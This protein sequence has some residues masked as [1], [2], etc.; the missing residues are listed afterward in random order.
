MGTVIKVRYHADID[1]LEY[2]GGAKSNWIDLRCAEDVY[3]REGEYRLI[4]LG[5]SIQLPGGY[6]AIVAPRSST[7]KS[8]G[9]IM[10]NSIGVIDEAYCGDGDVWRFP[11]L[12]VRD[13]H[14]PFNSRIAQFRI[15]EHQPNIALQT[16]E[17]LQNSNRGGIGSSGV[18]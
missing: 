4:S 12:A 7:L 17:Y 11:A 2:I 15:I 18:M 5:V 9:I 8:F 16:V 1:L 3:M 13:T 10:G 14:I 6:E